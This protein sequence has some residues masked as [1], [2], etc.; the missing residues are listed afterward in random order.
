MVFVP[1]VLFSALF[2]GF[3]LHFPLLSWYFV[4]ASVCL[5]VF[6][7]CTLLDFWIVLSGCSLKVIKSLFLLHILTHFFPRMQR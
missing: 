4:L 1:G 5:F 7:K 3:L 2:L 6:F